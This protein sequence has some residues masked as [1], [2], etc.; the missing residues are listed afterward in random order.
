MVLYFAF[1]WVELVFRSSYD[2]FSIAVLVLL[3]SMLTWAPMVLF[4]KEVWLRNGEV[5]S[6]FFS[7]L[8]EFAPTEVRVSDPEACRKCSAACQDPEGGCRNCYECCAS[9]APEDRELDVRPPAVGLGHPG[10]TP[11]GGVAFIILVLAGVTF[12]GL[13]ETPLWSG[14]KGLSPFPEPWSS[15]QYRCFS[16]PCT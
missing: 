11:P 12:D 3:Y 15:S 5:F 13:L 4:G 10:S 7:I 16:L 9:A 1:A 8:A 6:V 14:W 2:P